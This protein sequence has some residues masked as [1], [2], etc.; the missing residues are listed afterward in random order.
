MYVVTMA[1]RALIKAEAKKAVPPNP[2]LNLYRRILREVP[3]VL[4][5]YDVDMSTEEA[6]IPIREA[7]KSNAW[8]KDPRTIELLCFMG[9]N[10]LD[11]ATLQ[12]KTKSQLMTFLEPHG[13]TDQMKDAML[14]SKE[15]AIFAGY[16]GEMWERFQEQAAKKKDA[17]I[18]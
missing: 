10:E 17:L 5:I 8:V 1:L 15:D 12:Y 3:R 11:E 9:Q 7:F 18:K 4:T 6:R 14:G 13:M 2:A 16:D